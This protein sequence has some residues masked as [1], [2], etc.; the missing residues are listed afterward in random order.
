MGVLDRVAG[1]GVTVPPQQ[2]TGD[3]DGS[4]G[5]ARLPEYDSGEPR[6]APQDRTPPSR[7]GIGDPGRSVVPPE[8]DGLSTPDGCR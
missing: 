3:P 1:R 5:R 2:Q 6:S 4:P 7:R 8:G